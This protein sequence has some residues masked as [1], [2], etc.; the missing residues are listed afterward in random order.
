M[1]LC[2]HVC[3]ELKAELFVSIVNKHI[4]DHDNHY[5]TYISKGLPLP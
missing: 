1:Y 2:L 4:Y 3:M 5:T